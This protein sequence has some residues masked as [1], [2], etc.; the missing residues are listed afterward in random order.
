MPER[1]K[2]VSVGLGLHFL[3]FLDFDWPVVCCLSVLVLIEGL[4][5]SVLRFA[6]FA[7]SMF[8]CVCSCFKTKDG[9]VY[10]S[11]FEGLDLTL[12]CCP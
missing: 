1:G 7:P 10:L 4:V 6:L 2:Y 11:V 12:F 9:L 3:I 5:P 8:D